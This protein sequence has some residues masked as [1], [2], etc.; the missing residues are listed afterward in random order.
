M[1]RLSM[2]IFCLVVMGFVA[3][4]TLSQAQEHDDHECEPEMTCG[5]QM[6]TPNPKKKCVPK[7]KTGTSINKNNDNNGKKDA[8]EEGSQRREVPKSK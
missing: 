2:V 1:K 8:A 7:I 3:T 6:A 4:I 5:D